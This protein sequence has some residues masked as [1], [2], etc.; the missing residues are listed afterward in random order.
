MT[1][2]TVG[3]RSPALADQPTT[4][5]AVFVGLAAIAFTTMYFVSD[6]VEV[7]QGDFSPFRLTL[8]Y[9]SEAAIPL[10]VVCLYGVQRPRIGRLGFV[11]ALA[12]AYSYVFFTGTVMYALAAGTA[13]YTALTAVF[14]WWMTV[15]GLIMIVGGVAFGVAVVRAGVLPPWTGVALMAGVILVAAASGLPTIAR[16]AAAAVPDTAFIGMGFA[17]LRAAPRRG[18][19]PP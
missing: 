18:H 17:L 7:A 9:L 16:T 3:T 11:G 2:S 12:F 13:N 10:I 6:L 4:T 19:L 1:L 5:T 15:H 8:T 14:G